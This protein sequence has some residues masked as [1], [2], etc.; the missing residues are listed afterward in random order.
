MVQRFSKFLYKYTL[1]SSRNALHSSSIRT[2]G[3]LDLG[4]PKQGDP[5]LFVTEFL[6]FWKPVRLRLIE[7]EP[8]ITLVVDSGRVFLRSQMPQAD[9]IAT[10]WSGTWEIDQRACI[11]SP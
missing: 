6:G 1:G 10:A 7:I 3:P 9:V 4:G 11:F 5:F 2:G 8:N